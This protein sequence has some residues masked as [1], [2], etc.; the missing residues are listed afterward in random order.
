MASDALK[1]FREVRSAFDQVVI[2]RDKSGLSFELNTVTIGD[3]TRAQVA[4]L[5]RQ[6]EQKP[7]GR[8]AKLLLSG[9]L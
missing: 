3:R 5:T 2:P 6:K 1:P 9:Q 4:E 7:L 8:F